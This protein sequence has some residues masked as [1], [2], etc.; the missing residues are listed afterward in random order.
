MGLKQLATNKAKQLWFHSGLDSEP[1]LFP[2]PGAPWRWLAVSDNGETYSLCYLTPTRY[3]ALHWV[4]K[5]VGTQAEHLYQKDPL[6][7]YFVDFSLFPRFEDTQRDKQQAIV[8]EDVQWWWALPSRPMAFSALVTGDEL[9]SVKESGKF[10]KG[11]T[12][13]PTQ[14]PLLSKEQVAP[15]E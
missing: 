5:G 9:H 13:E 6:L 7:S 1:S 11:P 2:R 15:N 14:P 12:G 3:D 4:E 10:D 8:V